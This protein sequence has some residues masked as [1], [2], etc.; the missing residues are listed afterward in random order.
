MKQSS[1]IEE[2]VRPLQMEVA[3]PGNG[4]G[5][6]LIRTSASGNLDWAW[7]LW[8]NR[9]ALGRWTVYGLVIAIIIAFLIPAQYESVARLMPAEKDSG[10][11]GM[12]M[13]AAMA[14]GTGGG[15][16]AASSLL[17]GSAM[18]GIASDLLGMHDPGA[19]WSDML[20]SRTVLDGIID[21]F[22]LLKVYWV[23]YREVARKRL[24]ER[25]E[26]Q[27]DRKSGVITIVVRDRDRQRAQQMAQ[28]YVDELDRL[29][30]LVSTSAA[31]RERIFLEQRLRQVKLDLAEASG[32]FAQYASKNTVIDVDSQTKAMV[33]G[34]AALQGQLIAAQSEL[35]GLQQ[36]YTD[37]N[38]RIRSLR[39]RVDELRS[40]LQ[41]M[42]GS[43]ASL[44]AT[45]PSSPQ[46]QSDQL[47]PSIRKLP[48]LGVRWL[49]LYRETKI[50]QAIYEMLTEEYE[51]A[52]IEEAKEIP[53]VKVLDLPNFPERKAYPPRK[54]IAILGMLLS[55]AGGAFW[56]L[57]TAAWQ[58]MD[59]QDPRKQ[60]GQE[61]ASTCAVMWGRWNE[62]FPVI[63]RTAAW[64]E[65]RKSSSEALD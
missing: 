47:Y 38:V 29:N 35:E 62:R 12:A 32:Q 5:E 31:R 50:Q 41:K 61:V 34:G 51:S 45:T 56:L 57:G 19:V 44:D 42:G 28:A 20:R 10:G 9:R 54:L 8:Q 40:Q 49:D 60:F 17:G 1:R 64:W 46:S 59:P 2:S 21:R 4:I 3:E 6:H 27:L 58:H 11:T 26:I 25:T 23:R 43:N 13:M 18:G 30:A 55:F 63:R 22:D 39:A 36:V 24:A 48:L 7:L 65:R 16:G 37:N 14:G 52:K 33:E 53:T 15:G